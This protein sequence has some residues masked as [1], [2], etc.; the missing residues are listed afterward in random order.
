DHPRV[1]GYYASVTGLPITSLGSPPRVR[2]LR[3]TEW[4]Y[5]TGKR[6]TPACAGITL[7]YPPYHAIFIF[8]LLDFGLLL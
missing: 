1:C 4:Q 5:Y 8:L 6:I 2:V 7:K 3:E